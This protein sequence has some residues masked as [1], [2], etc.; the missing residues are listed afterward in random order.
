MVRASGVE[1]TTMAVAEDE[2]EKEVE[3]VKGIMASWGC[4]EDVDSRNVRKG[5]QKMR[6]EFV[7]LWG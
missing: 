1:G 7:Y 6:E 4:P 3:R 5:G 2:S